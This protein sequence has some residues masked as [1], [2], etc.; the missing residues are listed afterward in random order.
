MRDEEMI[1]TYHSACSMQ[2][3]QKITNHPKD[4][5]RSA[6]Y[7][8]REPAEGHLCCGSAG[9]YNIMQSEIADKLKT[10]KV[11]NLERTKPDVIAAGNIGC[12]TQIGSGTDIPIIHTI[13]LLNWAYGG[14]KPKGI[15]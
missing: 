14:A 15:N 9:T 12:I 13:E 3:G 10:R 2:H 11:G 4:L 1:V 8:V 5:L 6:G 7:T